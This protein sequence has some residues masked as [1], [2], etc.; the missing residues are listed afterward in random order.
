M[1]ALGR[2]AVGSQCSARP[3][4]GLTAHHGPLAA[5][6]PCLTVA[7]SATQVDAT[8]TPTPG[9][10]MAK[11]SEVPGAPFGMGWLAEQGLRPAMEDQITVAWDADQGV[12]FAAVWDGH[13]GYECAEWLGQHMQPMVMQEVLKATSLPTEAMAAGVSIAFQAAD[14]QLLAHLEQLGGEPLAQAGST[15]TVLLVWPNRLVAANVGDSQAYIWRKGGAVA[16]TTPHRV[17]GSGPE[18]LIEKTRVQAAGGWVYD[19]RVCNVLAVS[20]AF[21]D[22]EF[23]GKGLQQLLIEGV[24]RGFWGASFP[25]T[26]KFTSDPVIATP[27]TWDQPIQEDDE[28][29]VLSSDGLWDVMPPRDVMSWARKELMK[30]STPQEVAASLV[31]LADKRHT[32]DNTS[33]VVIDLKG[34]AHWGPKKGNGGGLF[35]GLFGNK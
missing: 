20:R 27:S 8:P 4:S 35:G 21:G 2:K 9:M 25:A 31:T 13:G 14:T 30:G 3:V 32:T 33:V 17:E 28:F 19:G 1:Q 5:P 12:L 7:S 29:I 10:D 22:W 34:S 15:G 16:L 11:G 24:E 6:K 26:V 23:K 18:V